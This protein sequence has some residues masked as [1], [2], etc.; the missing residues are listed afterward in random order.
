MKITV[1]LFNLINTISHSVVLCNFVLIYLDN[2]IDMP[3]LTVAVSGSVQNLCFYATKYGD[4][5]IRL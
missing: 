5:I 1:C 2:V 3:T 4:S